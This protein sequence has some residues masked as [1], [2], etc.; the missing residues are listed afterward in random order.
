MIVRVNSEDGHLPKP[1]AFWLD[2]PSRSKDYLLH[3]EADIAVGQEG[4][5]TPPM[6]PYQVKLTY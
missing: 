2:C 4:V 1:S 6:S 5:K 3:A